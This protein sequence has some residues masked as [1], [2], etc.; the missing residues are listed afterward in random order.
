M[1]EWETH[2]GW[3]FVAVTSAVTLAALFVSP[4]QASGAPTAPFTSDF[5]LERCS[6]S[7]TGNQN[8]YFSL[9]PGT[10]TAFEGEESDQNATIEVRNEITVLSATKSITFKTP[11]GKTLT[12]QARVVRE[13][14]THD[15][16]LAEI[17]RNWFA[18]CTQTNDIFYFG[19][20]VD[21]YENGA[22]V[23]HDGSWTA[24][25]NGAQPGL[26][27][28]ARF[29]LGSRYL[30]EIAAPVALDEAENVAMGLTRTNPVG[31]FKSCV[32]V[33][34]VD[35][36]V[37]ND[38]GEEKVYCPVVGLVLDDTLELVERFAP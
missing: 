12:V 26:A 32:Q 2:L 37:K 29:L 22:I 4:R 31:N 16:E 23:S 36:I 8:L 3:R 18:R 27:M 10:F 7:S 6:W 17:S 21:I 13:R 5:A 38:P 9:T 33:H 19:E 14:E 30:Q 11:S 20:S 34:E 25:V 1:R 24:G 35:G 15:G 28:P